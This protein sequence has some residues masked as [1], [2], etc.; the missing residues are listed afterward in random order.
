MTCEDLDR[1]LASQGSSA[2]SAARNHAAT[3]PRCR[4]LLR[5]VA[6][7]EAGAGDLRPA[8]ASEISS[9]IA[10]DLTPVRPLPHA[11]LLTT[12]FAVIFAG[13]ALLGGLTL[14]DHALSGMDWATMLFTF[15]S[16]AVSAVLLSFALSGQMAPGS[17]RWAPAWMLAV[18]VLLGIAVVFAVLFPYG[19]ENAFWQHAWIC[20]RTGLAGGAVAATLIWLV[21]RRGAVLDPRASGALAGLLGG[22]TG[23]AVL[24]MHCP[25]F[26]AVHILVGHWGAALLCAGIGW[27]A[28]EIAARRG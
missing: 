20:L 25:D 9:R 10:A 13:L 4:D 2:L 14:G 17:R 28:G 26:N 22:L 11:G 15:A 18:G 27:I 3:C 21:L 19:H 12:A 16:L 8:L 5:A 1:L 6:V 23:T 7:D 24:E